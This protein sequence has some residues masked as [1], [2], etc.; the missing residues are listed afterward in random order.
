MRFL[1]EYKDFKNKEESHRSLNLL[2][3]FLNEHSIGSYH[4]KT[5]ECIL[6]RFINNP[7][8]KKKYKKRLLYGDIAELE[9]AAAFNDNRSLNIEDFKTAI[10]K[11][12]EAIK[13]VKTI[14]IKSK[15]DFYENELLD[16]FLSCL[17]VAPRTNE[18]LKTYGKNKKEIDQLNLEKLI[19]CSIKQSMDNPRQL[20]KRLRSISISSP[21]E[22]VDPDYS[23]IYTE[24]FSN[25]LR[26]AEVMLPGYDHIF[27]NLADTMLLAKQEIAPQDRG[28]YTYATLNTEQFGK[29]NEQNRSQMMLK[30]VSA[31][32]RYISEFE[33]LEKEKIEKVIKRVEEEG[34]DLTLTY[35]S[36]RNSK[37]LAEVIYQVPTSHLIK[38]S[39]KLK[40][41]DLNTNAV[42]V[43]KIDDIDLY[44]CP[45]T[46]GSITLKK[47]SVVIK[48]RNS[49]RAELSRKADKLP[50]EYNFNFKDIFS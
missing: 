4:G 20:T 16:S 3:T 29:S 37:Y 10:D 34:K 19:N 44:W 33:H 38:A 32:L 14:E 12:E 42:S 11:V 6:I 26:K 13:F 18:E 49:Y 8:L 2:Q 50:D 23:F 41:T 47:D 35:F 15:L 17:K 24:I 39:F 48:G 25:L 9:I 28:K 7:P 30:S 43:V 36:K 21:L 27:I 31:A 46:L 40:V 1:I 5:F 22:E 45:Y